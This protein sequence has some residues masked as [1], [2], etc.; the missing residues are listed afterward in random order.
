MIYLFIHQN[1][2]GQYKHL[3]RHLADDPANTVYFISQPNANWMQGVV[4]LVYYP[5]LTSPLQCHPYTI[6]FELAVR[7]GTAVANSLR[8]LKEQGVTPDIILGHSGWGETLF[9]KDIYPDVPLLAY[10]EFFYHHEGVDVDF[11]PEFPSSPDDSARLRVRNAVNLLSF[12]S[13][14]WGNTPTKWQQS[15]YPPE[16]QSRISV[17]HEGIDTD[18]IKPDSNAWLQLD[19]EN[20]ILTRKDEIITYVARN[21]EP[22][23]GFHVFMRALPEIQR[24]R[25]NARILIVGGDDVSYGSPLR[26]GISFR[27]HMLAELEGQLDLSRIH[28]LGQL[29]YENYI[30]LLQVSSVHVYLTYP[31]VLSWSLLEAMAAGCVI[32]GSRTPPVQE[33]IEDG[34]NGFLVDFFDTEEIAGMVEK[35]LRNIG[36]THKN[37]VSARRT[38]VEGYDLEARVLP[39][40]ESLTHSLAEDGFNLSALEARDTLQLVDSK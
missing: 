25:P 2:P 29:P 5:D 35:V 21:L 19:R 24:R 13:A 40:W 10:F 3:I 18:L 17:I 12:Q 9:V 31:F 38:V 6:D 33:V 36:K 39:L 16:M 28:F 22:Y 37:G 32:V 20:L 23:R 8:M 26:S 4:K 7:H 34:V 27:Q 14:D 1:F 30:S 11:D 15:L